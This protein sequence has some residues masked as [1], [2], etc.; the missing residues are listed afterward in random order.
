ML[1][2]NLHHWNQPGKVEP[3]YEHRCRQRGLQ[4]ALSISM[5]C[6]SHARRPWP[7]VMPL[8]YETLCS[9]P[10]LQARTKWF[11]QWLLH[12]KQRFECKYSLDL[13]LNSSSIL[14]V[15]PLYSQKFLTSLHSGQHPLYSTLVHFGCSLGHSGWSHTGP[16]SVH[17]HGQFECPG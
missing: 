16:S 6:L 5:I 8:L 17:T 7:T 3:T 15:L 2:T 11:L 4:V 9:L 1:T 14:Y 12:L 13:T 10:T